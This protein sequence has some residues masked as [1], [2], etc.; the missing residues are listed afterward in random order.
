MHKVSSVSSEMQDFTESEGKKIYHV[1]KSRLINLVSWVQVL[2]TYLP[3]VWFVIIG[4]SAAQVFKAFYDH[5][6]DFQ[7]CLLFKITTK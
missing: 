5:R 3:V 6:F 7:V 1:S 2:R 4:V